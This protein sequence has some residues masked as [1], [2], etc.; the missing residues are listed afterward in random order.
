MSK[1]TVELPDELT[2]FTVEVFWKALVE[3]IEKMN[4]SNKELL[5]LNFNALEKIDGSGIQLLLSLEK[6]M[7]KEKFQVKYENVKKSIE[8][9]LNLVGVKYLLVMAGEKDE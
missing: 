8:E 2:I 6:T 7:L 5:I 9:T 4:A 1:R 3:S